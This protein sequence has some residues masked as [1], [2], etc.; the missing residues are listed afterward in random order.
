MQH[1][2]IR[3]FATKE[4]KIVLKDEDRSLI[5]S[6]VR[7]N[8]T[9]LTWLDL[10]GN[11]TWWVDTEATEHL[12]NFIQDQT[13]LKKIKLSYNYMS[14]SVTEQVL[15]AL[16]ESGSIDTIQEI[17]LSLSA[18]LSSDKACTL[19]AQIIDRAPLLEKFNIRLGRD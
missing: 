11:D 15:S 9:Q 7:S 1:L 4:K 14:S 2:T 13:K 18:D 16:L 8:L 5:N 10:D 6:L 19:F 12:C 17:W 3:C